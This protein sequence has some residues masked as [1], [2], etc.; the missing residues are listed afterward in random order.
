[1]GTPATASHSKYS[2]AKKGKLW[3]F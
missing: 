1:M 2:A 3:Y